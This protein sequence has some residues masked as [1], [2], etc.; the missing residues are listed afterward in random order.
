MDPVTIGL[1]GASLLS[2]LMGN[3]KRT[4]AEN[5]YNTD[6][7]S[8][9]DSVDAN[10][11]DLQNQERAQAERARTVRER[12][13]QSLLDTLRPDIINKQTASQ[14]LSDS[15]KFSPV[16]AKTNRSRPV[17]PTGVGSGWDA[18][19]DV[20]K[21]LAQGRQESSNVK[22]YWSEYEKKRKRGSVIA[23]SMGGLTKQANAP[24]IEVDQV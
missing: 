3:R 1:V 23:K 13:K 7:A 24:N 21:T 20:T 5:T 10:S 18:V 6:M 17:A 22:D 16:V 4:K 9:Q 12:L 2:K 8:Y 14:A 15:A 19:S 11:I